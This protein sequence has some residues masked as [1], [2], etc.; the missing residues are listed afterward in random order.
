ME[1]LEKT[2]PRDGSPFLENWEPPASFSLAEL[3]RFLRVIRA[4]LKI[5]RH[6]QLFKW[7]QGEFQCLVPNQVLVCAWGDFAVGPIR[8]DIVS[9]L[10]GM[11][12][13]YLAKSDVE[14]LIAALFSLWIERGRNP[15]QVDG[16]QEVLAR[17]N[18]LAGVA[19]LPPTSLSAMHSALV[20]GIVDKRG[21][22][23]GFFMAFDRDAQTIPG[24]TSSPPVMMFELL[25]PYIDAALRRIVHLHVETPGAST[26]LSNQFLTN[27][28]L[29]DRE[30]EI[31]EWVRMG[32]TNI[33]IGIILDLSASTVKSHLR[34]IFNKLDVTNRAQAVTKLRQPADHLQHGF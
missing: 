4:S 25:V 19:T 31:M 24:Q 2:L 30:A 32:K 17:H 8:C 10:P 33:E 22:D 12:T 1:N 26:I 7:V 13:G 18:F 28:A 14:P 6:V 16:W 23:H 3:E 20:H 11:R 15:C 27:G 34:R 29:S 21:S 9:A 5:E